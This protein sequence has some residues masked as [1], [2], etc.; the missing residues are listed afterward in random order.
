MIDSADL[1]TV[2]QLASECPAFTQDALRWHI[3]NAKDNGLHAVGALVRLGRRVYLRKSAF[4]RW[5][6]GERG[7]A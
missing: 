2:R 5:V 1:R 6:S 7:P 4:D 3:F